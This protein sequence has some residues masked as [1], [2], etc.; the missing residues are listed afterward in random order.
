MSV[1][2]VAGTVVILLLLIASNTVAQVVTGG[3][4]QETGPLDQSQASSAVQSIAQAIAQA[5]GFYVSGSLP[6]RSNNPG[7]LTIPA[8]LG[9][10]QNPLNAFP[11]AQDGW[12]ALYGEINLILNGGSHIYTPDMSIREIAQHWTTDVPPGSQVNWASNVARALGISPDQSFNDY[13]SGNV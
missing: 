9:S 12:D 2:V 13:V 1:V 6:Q 8:A 11:S 5:E 10:G 7:S 4:I 3:A